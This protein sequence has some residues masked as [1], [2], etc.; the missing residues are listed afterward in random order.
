MATSSNIVFPVRGG[1]VAFIL[2][3]A[4]VAGLAHAAYGEGDYGAET[5]GVE[6]SIVA[7]VEVSVGGVVIGGPLG[8]GYIVGSASATTSQPEITVQTERNSRRVS[9]T[10]SFTHRLQYLDRGDDV[11]RLQVYLNRH[12]FLL[13]AGGDGSPGNETTFF[14]QLTFQALV[15]FQE[16]HA[17]LILKPLGLLRAT[18][19]F[20]SSTMAFINARE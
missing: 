9:L 20:G 13:A 6:T 10:S 11:E 16:A 14:G 17:D 3:M 19:Y 7:P 1:A 8:I 18:G 4:G 12:G 5:F 15:R 2:L